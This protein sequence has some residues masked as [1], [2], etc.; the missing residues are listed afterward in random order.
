MFKGDVLPAGLAQMPQWSPASVHDGVYQGIRIINTSYMRELRTGATDRAGRSVNCGYG[1]MVWLNSCERT[2]K[3]VNASV[4]QRR[5]VSPTRPWIA[6]APRDMYYSWG[7]HGQHT[8]VIPSLD[9]V[10][11]RSGELP[12]DTLEGLTHLDPDAPIAGTLK[13]GYFKFFRILM[14]SVNSMPADVDIAQPTGNYKWTPTVDF[15][16]D[17]FIY[18]IDAPLGSYLGIG[19]EAPVGC[20]ILACKDEPNDGLKW[21]LDVP[22]VVP[23]IFGLDRRPNG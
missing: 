17:S 5:E 20:T 18:P 16:A 19:K 21:V 13:G 15:D 9:M 7:L 3:Q 12:P 4:F 6:S 11:T 8:F 14:D 1:Y 2:G 22:R 23:G 10:I